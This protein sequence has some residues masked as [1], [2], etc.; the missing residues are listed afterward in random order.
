MAD[1]RFKVGEKV[2]TVTGPGF[3]EDCIIHSI[4]EWEK[5]RLPSERWHYVVYKLDDYGD[6]HFH[7]RRENQLRRVI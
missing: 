5:A 6:A 2:H 1:P 3:S 4:F 7:V